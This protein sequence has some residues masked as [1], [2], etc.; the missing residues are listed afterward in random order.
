MVNI[1]FSTKGASRMPFNDEVEIRCDNCNSAFFV[2]VDW[3]NYDTLGPNKYAGD[4]DFNCPNC[5]K[6]IEIWFRFSRESKGVN[7]Y[8]NLGGNG[9]TII[10]GFGS[11]NISLG[12]RLYFLEEPPLYLP[13]QKKIVT[14]LYEGVSDL[15]NNISQNP[16]ILYQIDP[17]LF[18]KLV[19]EI[20]FRHGFQVEL[21]KKTRD[22]GRDIIAIKSDLEIKSKYIIECKR[23]AAHRPVSIDLVRSLYGVQVCEGA[24]KSVLATTSYFTPDAKKFAD[25]ARSTEWAMDLKGYNDVMLWISNTPKS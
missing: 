2:P 24:N 23:Y 12:E 25:T 10:K 15:I 22:G 6:L 8:R 21:T 1:G 16:K 9:A 3:I 4:F 7:S 20:F 13:E 17:R 19:A 5:D 18:E 11:E 14:D